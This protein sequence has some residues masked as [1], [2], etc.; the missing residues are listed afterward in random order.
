MMDEFFRRLSLGYQNK[1]TSLFDRSAD[2]AEAV[3][4]WKELWASELTGLH[5]FQIKHGMAHLFSVYADFPPTVGE[6]VRLCRSAR[7]PNPPAPRVEAVFDP[8]SKG[9]LAFKAA[10]I[11]LGCGKWAAAIER[12]GTNEG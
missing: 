5:G 10:C 9:F 4:Q 8:N 1:F 3:E 6:F 7:D 11:K 12:R 2:P